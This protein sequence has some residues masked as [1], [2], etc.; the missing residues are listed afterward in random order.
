[1]SSWL[2]LRDGITSSTQVK[3]TPNGYIGRGGKRRLRVQVSRKELDIL[4]HFPA[5]TYIFGIDLETWAAFL[6]SANE[7]VP[8]LADFPTR[9]PL[10]RQ[11]MDL[12]WDEVSS[13]WA[14]RD[15]VLRGSY[16]RE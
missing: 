11:N 9:F 3:T 1:M 4:E 7:Y 6:L 5:P 10:N 13:Y 12:L 2:A 8:R 15:M 16:F 14:A